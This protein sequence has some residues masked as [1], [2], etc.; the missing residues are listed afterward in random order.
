MLCQS[1]KG[2]ST[3]LF[4][5]SN[6]LIWFLGAIHGIDIATY[7]LMLASFK[8]CPA[9]FRLNVY[10][11]ANSITTHYFWGQTWIRFKFFSDNLSI[12]RTR[13]FTF[14]S[15]SARINDGFCFLTI[16]QLRINGLFRYIC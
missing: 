13:Y 1:D 5:N 10:Q 15:C 16:T 7:V 14:S 4:T 9:V 12:F 11:T 6:I 3:Y 2:L 8:R